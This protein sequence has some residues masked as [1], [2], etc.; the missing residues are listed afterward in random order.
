M[1]SEA[2]L[3]GGSPLVSFNHVIDPNFVNFSSSLYTTVRNPKPN[4]NPNRNPTVIT[5]PQIGARDP[6]IVTVQI[7]PSPHFVDVGD[8]LRSVLRVYKYRGL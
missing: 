5:G 3:Q 6:Q 2:A 7:R 4:S 1:R 8:V